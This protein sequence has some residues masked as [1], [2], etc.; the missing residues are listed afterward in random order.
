MLKL[1]CKYIKTVEEFIAIAL[2]NSISIVQCTHSV[3]CFQLNI[4]S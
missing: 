1:V 4:F 2:S 3:I